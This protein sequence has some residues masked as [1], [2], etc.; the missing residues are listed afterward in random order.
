[1]EILYWGM[2]GLGT[3]SMNR[4]IW[5]GIISTFEHNFNE[6]LNFVAGIDARYYVGQH[7]RKVENLLGN[8]TYQSSKDLNNI[9]NFINYETGSSVWFICRK[10]SFR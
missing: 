1:M 7:Y 10:F 4:H 5:Y 2:V 3:A 6:N 8:T 9:E